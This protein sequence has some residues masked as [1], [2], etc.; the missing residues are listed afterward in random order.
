MLKKILIISG[1]IW[2][3]VLIASIV[4]TA[5]VAYHK[6]E[7]TKVL[8]LSINAKQSGEF[9]VKN[10]YFTPF[11]QFPNISVTLEDLTYYE[12]KSAN[13][14]PEE[15]P[16]ARINN[17]YLGL[18]FISLLKGNLNVNKLLID[19]GELTLITYPDSSINLLNAMR[20]L[21]AGLSK[22][23]TNLKDSLNVQP[24]TNKEF[25]SKEKGS[26]PE[27]IL[28]NLVINNLKLKSQNLLNDRESSFVINNLEADFNYVGNEANLDLFA[29]ILIEKI[30]LN[31]ELSFQ[32]KNFSLNVSSLLNQEKGIEIKESQLEFENSVFEFNGFFN[33]SNE[34]EILLNIDGSDASFNL[35]SQ[36]LKDEERKNLRKGDFLF[37]GSVTGKTFI[38]SPLIDFSFDLKN[39]DLINP[40]TKRKIKNINLRGHFNS[41]DKDDF[42]KAKLKI[43]TLSADFPNGVLKLSGSVNNFLR[44]EFDTQIFLKADIAGLDQVF[45][46]DFITDLKGRIEISDRFRGKYLED[47]KRFSSEINIGEIFLEDFGFN[48]PNALKIDK[49]NGNISRNKE[50]YYFHNLSVLSD[51]TDLLINGKIENLQYLILNIEKE[52][53]AELKIKSSIFDL[54]HFL[55]FDPSIKR[56]FP[57][58]ILE[59]D[60]DVLAKTSTTKALKFNSFPEIDLNIKNVNAT[61]ENFLPRLKVESGRFKVSEDLL[62]F[63]LKFDNFK[64]KFMDGEFNFTGEYNTS[65]FQPFYIKV[66]TDFTDIS[67]SV[68]FYDTNDTIPESLSGKLS[69]SFFTE[70]QFPLDSTFLKFINLKNGKMVYHSAKDT[71]EL[72]SVSFNFSDIYFNKNSNVNPLATLSTKGN[73]KANKILTKYFILDNAKLDI[74]VSNGEYEIGSGSARLFGERAK[75]KSYWNI[76]PFA[77]TPTY[78][79]KYDVSEFYAED[80]FSIYLEDTLVTGPLSLFMDISSSG[81]DWYNILNNMSGRINLSGKNLKFYGL[82]AD[83]L[84]EKFKRS[85]SFNLVDL[86]AVVLAGPVGIAVTKGTDFARIFIIDSGESSEITRLISHWGIDRGNFIIQDAA[87]TTNKNRVAAKGFINFFQNNLDLSIALLNKNGCSVFTQ[88]VY[89]DLNSPTLGDVKVVGSILAPVTNL[90]DDILGIDCDVFYSGSI[91]QPKN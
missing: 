12:Q 18:D 19:E 67:P 34:G 91:M 68:L 11:K 64:T 83:K 38:E 32:N 35:F 56:D 66:Q 2:I 75:G 46:L 41:G 21:K 87:F 36:L 40:K 55:S 73:L 23:E 86:G 82:D 5:L 9:E 1:V 43:D 51:D 17:F 77:E 22:K 80:M 76:K 53:N 50:D 20:S 7:I 42:S 24:K 45:K 13:R 61:V 8:L 65:K 15:L 6:N 37:K 39:V 57:Y 81:I 71:I 52:I 4:L 10:V 59:V 84:I 49:I 26:H 44:P 79:I 48:I 70:F 69:G 33:T 47:E 62:G 78:H 30:R 31:K 60:V 27:F 63:N 3:L 74:S 14:N 72:R 25:K 89:G 16:I 88:R 29:S 58:R 85:Q 90:I 28:K 54:P